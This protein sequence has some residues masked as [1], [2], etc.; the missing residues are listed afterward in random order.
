MR[1]CA[2]LLQ[3]LPFLV[4]W[5]IMDGKNILLLQVID[6]AIHSADLWNIAIL[7][8]T[9]NHDFSFTK[10]DCFLGESWVYEGSNRSPAVFAPFDM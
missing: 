2:N 4:V 8:V 5:N 7:K 6:V 10:C 3:N 9:P 1:W